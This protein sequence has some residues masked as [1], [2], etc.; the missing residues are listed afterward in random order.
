MSF[1]VLANLESTLNIILSMA[2]PWLVME[3]NRGRRD[4]YRRHAL[5]LVLL[6]LFPTHQDVRALVV[7]EFFLVLD[8]P[9]TGVVVVDCGCRWRNETGASTEY[10]CT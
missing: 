8:V 10:I 3:K 1:L 9:Y 6:W 7:E 5:G 4:A 2:G